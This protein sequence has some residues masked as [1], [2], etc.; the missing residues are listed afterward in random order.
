MEQKKQYV[1]ITGTS[2]GIGQVLAINLSHDYDIILHGRDIEKLKQTK[3]LCNKDKE[4]II[5][6]LDLKDVDRIEGSLSNFMNENKLEISHF[7]HSAGFMKMLPLKSISLEIMNTTF[8]TNVISAALFIKVLTQR[9]INS[10]ALKT[11]VLISSNISNFGAKAFSIYGA[12]K[13][14]LDALMRS[15]AVELAPK[16]RVN[17]ILPGA[18]HTGMTKN[19]FENKE[20]LERMAKD[21][22]LGLGEAIDIFE[23]VGFLISEK[24]K[25]ITGQQFT[26]D[27]GRTINISG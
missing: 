15:L 3:L 9:K 14:A 16:V 11:V 4:Q 5:F 18:I 12:S 26:V 13:G 20:G 23:L 21:Y 6:T 2:S 22:P 25:W 1:L 24:S 27:G 10:D 19:I 8:A 7:I 17:S